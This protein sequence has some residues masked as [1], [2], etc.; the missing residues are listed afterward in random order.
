MIIKKDESKIRNPF[1][2]LDS[3]ADKPEL[4]EQLDSFRMYGFE[5]LESVATLKSVRIMVRRIRGKEKIGDKKIRII[6][7]GNMADEL[8][9]S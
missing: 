6:C 3:N 1:I 9:E 8:M 4:K 7:S 5:R 2:W